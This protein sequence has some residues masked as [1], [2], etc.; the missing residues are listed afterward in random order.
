[1]VILI[2]SPAEKKH[3]IRSQDGEMKR[4]KSTGV[5]LLF[6]PNLHDITTQSLFL[7]SLQVSSPSPHSLFKRTKSAKENPS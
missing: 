7:F 3:T 4:K 2:S 5:S 1:M 6:W